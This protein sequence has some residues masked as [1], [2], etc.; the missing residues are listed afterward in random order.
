MAELRSRDDSI[1]LECHIHIEISDSHF[2][3]FLPLLIPTPFVYL[4]FREPGLLGDV[5]HYVLRP[6]R[7][8]VEFPHEDLQLV[9]TLSLSF[10]D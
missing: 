10:S 4:C 7:V 2:L 5:E 9:L 8:L 3:E 6:I 1:L